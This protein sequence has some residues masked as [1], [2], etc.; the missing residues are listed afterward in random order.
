MENNGI[1]HVTSAPYHPSTNGSTE[2]AVQSFKSAMRKMNSSPSTDSLR[3]RL[4]R[5]LFAY[6]T[7]PQTTTETS[8]AELLMNRKPATKL[9]LIKPNFQ[10]R[11]F[12]KTGTNLP[13]VNARS[14]TCGEEV[15]M[16]NYS[17]KEHKW[18]PGVIDKKTGPPVIP[19]P[20]GR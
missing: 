7:T 6:R 16:R 5:F 9:S 8:P 12:T 2:R 4:N 17:N 10:R 1:R 13:D 3:T 20:S 14:F 15:W 18:I 11:I 19:C